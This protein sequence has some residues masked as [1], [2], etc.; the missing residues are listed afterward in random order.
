LVK[1]LHLLNVGQ[2]VEILSKEVLRAHLGGDGHLLTLPVEE[3]FHVDEGRLPSLVI[4]GD[5][6]LVL[7]L[8][9]ILEDTPDSEEVSIE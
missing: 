8:F 3:D 2:G 9:L 6:T 1:H 5:E 7:P 4:E